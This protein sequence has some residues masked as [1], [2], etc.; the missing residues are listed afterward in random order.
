M[1][2]AKPRVTKVLLERRARALKQHIKAA[3][4]GD[5]TSVHQARVASRRLREAVP[6]LV[7][8]VKGSK[9]GRVRRKVR[10]LTRALGTFREA[11]VTLALLDELASRDTLPRLAL[12]EVR[13]DVIDERDRRLASML[14]RLEQVN[15]GKLDRRL[16][17]MADALQQ[18]EGEEWR[19]VLGTRLLKRARALGAAVAEAGQMYG[20]ERLHVVRINIKKLRYALEIAAETGTRPAGAPVRTLKRAQDLLGRLHDFQVLQTHVKAVQAKPSE[21]AQA[22]NLEVMA[23]AIEDECRHLHGHYVALIP[24]LGDV[25]ETTRRVVVPLIVRS[26][27]ARRQ[28]V[29]MTLVT[30]TRR[31]ARTEPQAAMSRV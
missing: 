3:V 21:G 16:V 30:R 13:R 26:A 9:A 25:V 12:E 14:K 17:T 24:A 2:R 11:D 8:G 28:P 27:P 29:K 18:A 19:K 7:R 23:R 31:R 4:E 22:A 6:V 20:P 10:R 15:L 1:N 5:G